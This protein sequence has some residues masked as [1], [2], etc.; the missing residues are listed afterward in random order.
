MAVT[1]ES[2]MTRLIVTVDMD[3]TVGA[4]HDLFERHRF[5][6]VLV[7]EEGR[8]A[9]VISDRDLLRTISPFVGKMAERRQDVASLRRKAHQ[10]MTRAPISVHPG[11]T[12]EEAGR[13]MLD[14]RVSCVPVVENDAPVGIVTWRDLLDWT[15]VELR[16]HR[17]AA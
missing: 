9:G 6:H 11:A 14:H 15:L 4:I 1:I 13:V 12:V 17:E 5:H 2:V 16:H 8:L 3:E 7:V 10:V